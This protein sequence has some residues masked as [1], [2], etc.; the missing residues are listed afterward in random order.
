MRAAFLFL[1]CVPACLLAQKKPNELKPITL[2]TM[3]EAGR[4][5]PQGPGNPAAW[6]PDGKQFLY[7]QGRK[8]IFYDPATGSSK[9]LI[10]TAAMDAAAELPAAGES[11]PFDW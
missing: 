7:R 11:Q 4:L 6:A 9:D 3:E 1:A 2:E 10:D 5:T 8:L